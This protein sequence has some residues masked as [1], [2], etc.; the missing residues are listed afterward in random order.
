MTS[1]Y[2]G[3]PIPGLTAAQQAACEA[4]TRLTEPELHDGILRD[5]AAN[6]GGAPVQAC[7]DAVVVAA[8][9]STLLDLGVEMPF[10][11]FLQACGGPLNGNGT[12]LASLA[13]RQTNN[14]A[15]FGASAG[16]SADVG[17]P[18]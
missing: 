13:Q 10:R 5:I 14:N 18:A 7:V 9:T 8:I 3:S 4:A 11:S 16:L 6:L 2:G 17:V 12:V 15:V 1:W